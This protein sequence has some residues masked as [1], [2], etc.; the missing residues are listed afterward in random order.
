MKIGEQTSD[1]SDSPVPRVGFDS[2][3]HPYWKSSH[4]ILAGIECN[5]Q[6]LFK[7]TAR[8]NRSSINIYTTSL[9]LIGLRFPSYLS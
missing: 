9:A 4:F 6:N 5:W 3:N 2:F 7:F 8:N 1:T